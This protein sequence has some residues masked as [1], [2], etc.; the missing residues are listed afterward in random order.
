[1]KLSI[2]IIASLFVVAHL[3]A[4]E[5]W[6]PAATSRTQ[7]RSRFS[8][9]LPSI[10][11]EVT[12]EMKT[13]M[14]AKDTVRLATIRLIRSGLQNAAIEAKTDKVNDEQAIAVLKKM[15]KMRQESIKMFTD[16]GATDRAELE[17]AELDVIGKWLPT[18]ADEETTRAWVLEAMEAAGDKKNMG[19][20]MGALMRAHK[21]DIDGNLA[22]EIVKEEVAKQ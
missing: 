16:G 15:A 12:T 17:Q 8:T 18:L 1:M 10:A 11:D 7:Q 9:S 13:A 3:G 4:A 2:G 21:A 14:K 5:A 22:K 20:I 6:V 19:K